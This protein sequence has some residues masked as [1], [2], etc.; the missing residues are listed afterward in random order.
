M[1]VLFKPFAPPAPQQSNVDGIPRSTYPGQYKPQSISNRTKIN[2]N[3]HIISQETQGVDSLDRFLDSLVFDPITGGYR[4]HVLRIE[5]DELEHA[6]SADQPRCAYVFSAR[7]IEIVNCWP[8]SNPNRIV[9]RLLPYFEASCQGG[10]KSRADS[11][12]QTSSSQVRSP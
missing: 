4:E 3:Q 1:T 12:C 11:P 6:R 9:H 8:H 2:L 10:P 5:A 7:G